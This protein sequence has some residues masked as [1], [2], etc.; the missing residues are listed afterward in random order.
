MEFSTPNGNGIIDKAKGNLIYSC[1]DF[2][3][4]STLLDLGFTRTYNSQSDK[5]G[6]LGKGWYDS[7]HK[8]LYQV[9]DKIIFQDSDGTYLTYHPKIKLTGFIKIRRQ[10][11]IR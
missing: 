10:E 2:S 8:Q 1:D 6:M 9:G 3:I 5:A 11:I 7:F 4:P